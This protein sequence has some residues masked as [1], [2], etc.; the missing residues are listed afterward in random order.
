MRCLPSLASPMCCCL[1]STLGPK[2][3]RGAWDKSHQPCWRCVDKVQ[4]V[5]CFGLFWDDKRRD[6]MTKGRERRDVAPS[7]KPEFF[8]AF[9]CF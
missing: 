8:A 6:L 1:S 7:G 9:R 2:V 5:F 4:L 3:E